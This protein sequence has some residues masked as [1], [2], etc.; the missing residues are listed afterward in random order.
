MLRGNLRPRMMVASWCPSAPGSAL[1]AVAGEHRG[2]V[3][4]AGGRLQRLGRCLE[5]RWMACFLFGF[6]RMYAEPKANQNGR[7]NRK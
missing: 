4:Q 7:C 1:K 2:E 6:A 3:E 5:R